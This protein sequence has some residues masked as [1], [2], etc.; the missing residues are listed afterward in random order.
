M[1]QENINFKL[2][3]DKF[4]PESLDSMTTEDLVALY[5]KI[6][7]RIEKNEKKIKELKSRL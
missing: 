3:P 7:E 4:N 6:S 5:N 2:N 1:V